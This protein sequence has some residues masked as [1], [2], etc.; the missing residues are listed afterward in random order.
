[1]KWDE[2]YERAWSRYHVPVTKDEL[3][4][5]KTQLQLMKDKAILTEDD[6]ELVNEWDVV[7]SC[8]RL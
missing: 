4:D 3:L 6:I 8:F 2:L 5:L 1:M 7:I